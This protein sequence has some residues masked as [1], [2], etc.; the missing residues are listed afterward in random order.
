MTFYVIMQLLPDHKKWW[1]ITDP[2]H[3]LDA[4]KTMQ[5][6]KRLNPN[7]KYKLLKTSY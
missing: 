3:Y 5:E 2:E 7:E 6:L 4:K 1:P